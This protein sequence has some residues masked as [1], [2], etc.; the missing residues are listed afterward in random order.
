MGGLAIWG[1][2]AGGCSFDPK[3]PAAPDAGTPG[4]P[5]PD[6]GHRVPE[7]SAAVWQLRP[8]DALQVGVCTQVVLRG[9]GPPAVLAAIGDAPGFRVDV[10][11]P[12]AASVF[13]D[14]ACGAAPAAGW[15]R[16]EGAMERVFSVRP[17]A[18]GN[19]E[20][21][22]TTDA[23]EGAEW[24]GVVWD[25]ADPVPRVRLELA[26]LPLGR[27][28]GVAA[29]LV[30]DVGRPVTPSGPLPLAVM[31]D[32]DLDVFED[33]RC[34][35]A[36]ASLSLGMGEATR[37]FGVRA[38][39]RGPLA[40]ALTGAR[41]GR[42][43][44]TGVGCDWRPTGAPYSPCDDAEAVIDRA[45]SFSE[46]GEYTLFFPT[47][48]LLAPDGG[49]HLLRVRPQVAPDGQLHWVWHVTDLAL[50]PE[51]RLRVEG[52]MPAWLV[53]H[54]RARWAGRIEVAPSDE[55]A[56]PVGAGEAGSP[57]KGDVSAGAGGGGGT[58]SG[59]GGS[60][61][62]VRDAEGGTGGE[63]PALG[64]ADFAG[65]C[66]G[67]A[68][69]AVVHQGNVRAPGGAGGRGGGALAVVARDEIRLAGPV[70]AAGEGGGGGDVQP[71]GGGG[72]VPPGS[73]GGGGGG[74]GGWLLLDAPQVVLRPGA[75]LC[76]TGGSGGEGGGRVPGADGQA[77]RCDGE[78]ARTEDRAEDGGDG[79][80]G[81]VS[82]DGKDGMRAEDRRGGGGGGGGAG[83]I[84]VLAPATEIDPDAVLYPE[85]R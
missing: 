58:L 53:V 22:A 19:I 48:Q 75:S 55:A 74:S 50:G 34:E 80:A 27:C 79:G 3:G 21:V 40:L 72:R 8:D 30:D 13:D 56:C 31:A 37:A 24:R 49:E 15:L 70:R 39:R 29:H 63:R 60:G 14:A 42:G 52:G 5:A 71:V 12:E 64:A 25:A 44:A 1:V 77:G 78:R 23:G 7:P 66:P 11:P 10:R 43:T 4:A 46:P 32:P 73:G 28:V 16:S 82:G 69:G 83:W 26:D 45:P 2:L 59:I 17:T 35:R 76:A 51:V 41:D 6:A 33:D 20:L 84:Q 57:S 67:G 36:A 62:S 85:P 54:G 47:G 81:G 18:P 61:A 38:R 68:G 9:E 65:G